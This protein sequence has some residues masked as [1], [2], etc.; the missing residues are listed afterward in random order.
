[1]QPNSW[2]RKPGGDRRN[3]WRAVTLSNHYED[4]ESIA[5]WQAVQLVPELRDHLF[6]VPNGGKRNKREAARLKAM[7]VRPGVH[8]Y[9]LPVARSMY[10]GL[11]IELKPDVKGYCPKVTDKQLEWRDKMIEQ[12]YAACIVKGW[13][14]AIDVMRQYLDIDEPVKW[15]DFDILMK[16]FKDVE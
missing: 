9:F 8:D 7:G 16:L 6:H 12:G 3:N 14:H 1:M 4:Q 15:H 5:L 11:W 10:H 2:P 13:V